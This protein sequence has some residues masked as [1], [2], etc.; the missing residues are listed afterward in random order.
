MHPGPVFAQELAH[1]VDVDILAHAIQVPHGVIQDN[2][3]FGFGVESGEDL[4]QLPAG[5]MSRVGRKDL[6]PFRS[7]GARQV[8]NAEVEG[9][10]SIGDGPLDGYGAPAIAQSGFE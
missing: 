2:E 3:H 4:L 5:W 8:M 9:L 6:H 1:L 10:W 7:P